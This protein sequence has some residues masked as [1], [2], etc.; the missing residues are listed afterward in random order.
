MANHSPGRTPMNGASRT[1]LH[2]LAMQAIL[3]LIRNPNLRTA[4]IFAIGGFAFAMG[5]LL[6]G[7]TMA[8]DDYS[9]F[10]LVI[11]LQ[12]VASN[13][14]PV[15]L[16]QLLL[17]QNIRLNFRYVAL[18]LSTTFLV[19]ALAGFVAD[20]LYEIATTLNIAMTVT[21][22]AFGT[23]KL[24]ACALRRHGR[25]LLAS[26]FETSG[27]TAIFFIGI[28]VATG[29]IVGSTQAACVFAAIG[30]FGMIAVFTAIW[31]LER[32]SAIAE[33]ELKSVR[34]LP[35]SDIMS[36][37]AIVA[38]GVTLLQIER[39]L[40]PLLLEFDDLATF[41][42]LTSVAIA[43][44]RVLSTG[45]L[46]S[47][48]QQ[49]RRLDSRCGQR[50]LLIKEIRLFAVVI[51][52][53]TV[54]VSLLAPFLADLL[55]Q[56][57][58]QLGFALCFAAC[59]NGTVKILQAVPRAVA[60]GIGST[61]DLWQVS[62]SMWLCVFGTAIGALLGAHEGLQA[63]ILMAALGNAIATLPSLITTARRLAPVI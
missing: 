14:G 17:R 29:T 42:I 63:F 26:I 8:R 52:L 9:Q 6:I 18:A 31:R 40:I 16:D 33:G 2:A 54:C 44:F 25:N 23:M 19:A 43:P 50:S 60:V 53:A 3:A 59:V 58:Y 61:S 7:R 28:L 36:L 38:A 55:T 12:V 4:S 41:S 13:I 56:G 22:I 45:I 24:G 37:W 1:S 5:N 34:D 21:T 46:A 10:A 57:R 15:G 35:W 27:D 20:G 48:T 39:L 30:T 32:A 51:L 47:L 62:T 49:L 11:A